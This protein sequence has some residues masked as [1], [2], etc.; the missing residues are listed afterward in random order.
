V[1]TPSPTPTPAPNLSSPR[2]YP[3]L[4][5]LKF[6]GSV[7]RSAADIDTAALEIRTW[8]RRGWKVVAVVSALEGT[9]DALIAR[10]EA[11]G[12]IHTTDPY[13]RALLLATG[14]LT[15][16]ALLGLTLGTPPHG[17]KATVAEPGAIGL[18][19][20]AAAPCSALDAMPVSLSP[21]AVQELLREH[22][23][24][25]VPGFIGVDEHRRTVLLGRGGS[26][27]TALFIADRLKAHCVRLIKDVDGLYEWDPGRE[28]ENS[29]AKSEKSKAESE[30]SKA[31][32]EKSKA[33]SEKNAAASDPGALSSFELSTFRSSLSASPRRYSSITW[34][35]A[36]A[37]GG[38]IVQPKAIRF[39]KERGLSFEVGESFGGR[40]TLVGPGPSVL[41]PAGAG[42]GGRSPVSV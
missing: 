22:D 20:D 15:S 1:T 31:E 27:L 41:E 9:T 34:D 11:I 38:D 42:R 3:R 40:P 10:A 28:S 18:T 25:V 21:V 19:A 36:L 6:G 39:A 5:V 16:A 29:K 2:L 30:T 37:L 8:T 4:V 23:A 32:S 26:D 17:V 33:E 13:S 24:V 7:L 35:D 14:E 12:P